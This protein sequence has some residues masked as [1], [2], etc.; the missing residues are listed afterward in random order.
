[1]KSEHQTVTRY[2]ALGILAIIFWSTSIAF[3][4][5]LT[6]ELGTF[7]TATYVNLASGLIGSSYF[8]GKSKSIQRLL[9]TSINYLIGCGA[10]FIAYMVCFY[11][12]IGFSSGRPQALIVGMINYLWPSFTLVFSSPILHKKARISLLPGIIIATLGVFLAMIH[13]GPFSLEILIENLQ[14]NSVPYILAFLASICWG[15]YSNLSR[16]WGGNIIFGAIPFFLLCT[17][18]VSMA[19]RPFFLNVGTPRWT[20]NIVAQFLYVVM[21]PNL[22]SY[23]FW[24]TGMRKGDHTLLA[25]LSY[26]IPLLSTIFSSLYLQVTIGLLLWVSSFLVIAGALVCKISI[27]D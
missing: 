16:R 4:R 15:L 19:V 14:L 1:M 11:L 27:I 25:S 2:T 22:L 5:S 7:T 18:L 20:L 12:A 6:E 3:S 24:D 26:L 10:L 9:D 21:F 8:I 13:T 23:V 17:G